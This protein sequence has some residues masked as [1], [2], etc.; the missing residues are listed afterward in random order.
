MNDIGGGV[1]VAHLDERSD[2]AWFGG[3]GDRFMLSRRRVE[4]RNV[5]ASGKQAEEREKIADEKAQKA[6]AVFQRS[7]RK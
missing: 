4:I 3:G 6:D 5:G 7:M 2:R 1:Q